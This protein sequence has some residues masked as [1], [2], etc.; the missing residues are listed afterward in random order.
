MASLGGSSS[1]SGGTNLDGVFAQ[2]LEL[3]AELKGRRLGELTDGTSNTAIFSEVKRGTYPGG[4]P[5]TP[6][7]TFDHTTSH[8]GGTYS[9][10][11]ITDGRTVTECLNGNGG[12]AKIHYIGQQYYRAQ[13]P[14][15]FAYTHT[16]PVN[17]NRKQSVTAQQR[18]ICGATGFGAI[19]HAAASYHP[20]GANLCLAD[21]STRIVTDSV[22][23]AIWQAAG[24][25][26]NGESTQLP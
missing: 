21:G 14:H 19:H 7:A 5:A 10:V 12:G 20:A 25:M 24:S 22:D 26:N 9:G 17:W 6:A 1:V 13:I 23:F 4:G 8:I 16:L 18:Y 11:T 2:P 15:T 3:G